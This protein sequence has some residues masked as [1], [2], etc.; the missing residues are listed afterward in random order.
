MTLSGRI[1]LHCCPAILIENDP[2]I[3]PGFATS[4][5]AAGVVASKDQ[6]LA[7]LSKR[8]M[9]NTSDAH[10]SGRRRRKFDFF[11]GVFGV[12]ISLCPWI[13]EV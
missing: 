3:H 1:L 4:L 5:E 13:G 6:K 12:A 7:D 8:V 9:H 10:L 11:R 2:A